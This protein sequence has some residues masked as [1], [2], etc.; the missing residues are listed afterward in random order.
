M[1]VPLQILGT[2]FLILFGVCFILWFF[3]KVMKIN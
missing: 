1:L 2:V 3:T